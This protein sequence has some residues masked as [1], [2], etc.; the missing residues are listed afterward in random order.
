MD[1][2][3]TSQV[4]A[5]VRHALDSP[6]VESRVDVLVVVVSIVVGQFRLVICEVPAPA[7]KSGL[8]PPCKSLGRAGGPSLRVRALS[9]VMLRPWAKCGHAPKTPDGG[10]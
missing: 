10:G 7:A 9:A 3:L 4:P 1:G 6:W 2:D 8:Y 5:F